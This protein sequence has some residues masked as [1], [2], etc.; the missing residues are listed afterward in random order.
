MKKKLLYLT[1]IV[2]LAV[3]SI[4]AQTK[5]WDFGANP[6]G[7][8]FTDM[9][10]TT[11][12]PTC[13]AFTQPATPYGPTAVST[14][15]IQGNSIFGTLTINTAAGDKW[16]SD[17]TS[18]VLSD[19]ALNNTINGSS[20]T[21]VFTGA[22]KSGR[23]AFNGGGHKTRRYLIFTLAAGQTITIYW[24]SQILTAGNLDVRGPVG[25]A[26]ATTGTIA[27]GAVAEVSTM[28][29]SKFTADIAGDYKIGTNLDITSS[30]DPIKLEL[31]RI[32]DADVN[33]GVNLSTGGFE[34]EI[35]LDVFSIKNQVY[36]SNIVSN[37][38]INVYSILGSLIKS[39]SASEDTSFELNSGVYVVK[40]QSAEGTKA[41]KVIVQ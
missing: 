32:Y 17:N 6:M 18:L 36:V 37:T 12:Q 30:T 1:S 10:T 3:S 29:Q 39:V 35:S 2:L 31:Y 24:K 7:A 8:G 9:I 5:V 4:N 15:C 20:I 22:T 28:H 33:A 14:A 23:L 16:R 27:Y 34:Q 19:A 11:N 25:S 40:A 13:A 26:F 38:K 21:P 41:V